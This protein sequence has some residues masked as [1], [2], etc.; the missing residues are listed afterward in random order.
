MDAMQITDDT[1]V[2]TRKARA[3]QEI[4]ARREQLLAMSH[5]IH[6]NPELSWEEHEAAA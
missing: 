5:A 2:G 1:A 6:S 4:E 3:S